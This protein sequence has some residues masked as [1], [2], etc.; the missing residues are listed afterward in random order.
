MSK[1]ISLQQDGITKTY[2]NVSVINTGSPSGS[3]TD[4]VPEDETEVVEFTVTQNGT[5]DLADYGYYGAYRVNVLVPGGAGATI[6]GA[7]PIGTGVPSADN[8]TVKA[9]YV[10]APA[11]TGSIMGVDP[12]TGRRV[13]LGVDENGYLTRTEQEG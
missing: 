3:R 12:T 1:N 5:Y 10:V 2:N 13:I 7:L 6:D 8:P 11:G 4:W 9:Q